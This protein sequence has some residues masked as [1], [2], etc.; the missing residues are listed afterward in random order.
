MSTTG[1]CHSVAAFGN[2][3]RLAWL[4]VIA[5]AALMA[6]PLS[7]SF[8]QDSATETPAA[9]APADAPATEPVAAEAPPAEPA[10]G[11]TKAA[12]ETVPAVTANPGDAADEAVS[13]DATKTP[14]SQA[15]DAVAE[16]L[17]SLSGDFNM[18]PVY[19]GL[20][21]VGLFV[22][23]AI[24]GTMLASWLNMPDYG[25]KISLVLGTLA[26]SIVIVSLGEF[27]FGP[28]LA[29]G[30]TLVYE[31]A[32]K[33]ASDNEGDKLKFQEMIDILKR[34]IDPTGT[35]EVTI[36]EYGP[37]IEIIIPN[38]GDD[39][40]DYIK[41]RITEM[42]QLEF[43]ITAD[44]TQPNPQE[45]E[46][47]RLAQE[48]PMAQTEVSVGGRVVAEWI[49]YKP[50][51]FGTVDSDDGRNIVKRMSGKTPQALVLL[52]SPALSVTGDYLAD[53]KKSINPETGGP[54]VAFKFNSQGARRFQQ[55]T[56]KNKPNAATG[57][58]RYL[59]IVLDKRLLS[60]PSIESTISSEG[61]ISGRSMG[62]EE[63]DYVVSILKEGRLPLELEKQPISEEIIS[64][65]LGAVTIESG[66][67][68]I[69]ISGLAIFAFMLI[70]YR[71]AGL[72][73]CLALA[74][75]ILLV[76]AVM[77]LIRAAFTLPGLA[78]LVLTMGMS[79]DANI[80]IFERM[81][82]EYKAGAALRMVIRN[83][84]DRAMSAILDS[85]ITTIISGI[86]L[87]LFATDQVKGFAVT[88]ILGILTSMYTAIFVSRLIF[89]ISER[90]GWVKKLTMLKV[91]SNPNY[92]FLSKRW[93]AI[94]A[95][96]IVIGIGMAA[97]YS[98]GWSL[99]D[100]DFTGGSSVTF[101]VNP[102]SKMSISDV[103]SEL[104]ETDLATRNLL[105][106][107]RGTSGT[108]FSVDT[109]EQSVDNV[110]QVIL[111]TFDDK[112]QMYTVEVGEVTPFT[113][114][115]FTG[116]Q[117]Q[118]KVNDGPGFEKDDGISHD[119]LMELVNGAIEAEGLKG[120]IAAADSPEFR[121]GSSTRIKEWNLRLG[122]ADQ[123]TARQVLSH[124][125]TDIE[126]MA[127]FPLANKI[128]GRVSSNMQV[129][130]L[131]ALFISLLG[132]VVYLWVRFEKLI[133][134][135]A[136]A[137]ALIHD[138]LITIG[139]IAI[140]KYVVEAVPGLATALQIDSFQIGLTIVA[141]LLTI[142]GYSVNDTIVT[143]D[144]LR[145]IKGKNPKLRPDMINGAVNQCL[146][147]TLLTALTVFI[148]VVILYFWGGD[149]IHGFA[150]AFLVGVVAGT[151]STVYI[152]APVLLWLAGDSVDATPATGK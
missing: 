31:L 25:W 82:E 39:A 63:V 109:S 147:R 26:A 100:I 93:A 95:S 1:S 33:P 41:R 144:R 106:V 73:A 13:T 29:G 12:A 122:G 89:D 78:G 124:L 140:S 132:M 84:F 74:F 8:G 148:T 6:S 19:Y 88:L 66:K 60:A 141:A 150:F 152:A 121:S 50:E 112:L 64:P 125:E 49:A 75:N 90:Q 53:V 48:L 117:A 45:R 20:I 35:R 18:R 102:E 142:I 72:V 68:A 96:L 105:V 99:L 14:P 137:T 58:R 46:I 91:L 113:E 97:V 65:T 34:R 76:V 3:H 54:Q 139:M 77:V 7:S 94:G 151:Y 56:S 143:F 21:I 79:V 15:A 123:T 136:A 145:E 43:R 135:L 42:G 11:D 59:G 4:Q 47:I 62:D 103:R 38:T 146:S 149:G 22:L 131:K 104:E 16:S 110:K 28:D 108:R 83:G 37:A 127:M 130:A 81:R 138:V 23:P 57:A 10:S 2:P 101:V 134:G 86:A 70:Y 120:I 67:R 9:S 36:R 80:L 118:L 27:K 17:E 24:I 107:E 32:E 85:N 98:R 55:L 87:Y 52:D 92:D 128:G 133:Y 126:G 129:D 61:Q 111:D 51:E 30:I 115:T 114:G 44:P 5:L 40:L 71:F 116:M 119:A 69:M